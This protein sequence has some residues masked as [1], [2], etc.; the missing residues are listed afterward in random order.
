MNLTN[1]ETASAQKVNLPKV[2][3]LASGRAGIQTQALDSST[4]M[5]C[6]LPLPPREHDRQ[7]EAAREQ[8]GLHIKA[9]Q[10]PSGISGGKCLLPRG[11]LGSR[12]LRMR[13]AV[14]FE[15]EKTLLRKFY[16]INTYLHVLPSPAF[17]KIVFLK[18][19]GNNVTNTYPPLSMES[20]HY[21]QGR[22]PWHLPLILCLQ[23]PRLQS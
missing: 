8:S 22:D 3:L 6:P 20:K 13:G 7:T 15:L 19:T 16:F 1:E 12:E 4:Q 11:N 23:L 17:L 10:E 9:L 21:K 5:S 18:G 2:T 14:L